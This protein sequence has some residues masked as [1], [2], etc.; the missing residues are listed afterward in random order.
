MDTDI[1]SEAK[2]RAAKLGVRNVLVAT[3]T[4]E[5]V[6]TAQHIMGPN[7][8]FFAVG[9][10]SSSQEKGWVLH[11]GI[12]PE[13]RTRLES[14]G[15]T[16][17]EQDL[18]IFQSSPEKGGDQTSFH[19]ANTAY[20]GRFGGSFDENDAVPN[21]ICR[22]M[23]HILGEF[24]G[25]GLCVCVEIALMAADSGKLPLDEDCVAISTPGGYPL[26]AIVVHPVKSADL[27]STH[28][29]IKD[30]L[31]VPGE[32]DMWFNDGPIP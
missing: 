4:G 21:N 26:T 22:V 13:T 1:F 15:I 7:F 2:D 17:V 25:D 11:C 30:V 23:R 31:F 3:N 32:K 18:S 9:N 12:T 19:S 10:P 6:E 16:V 8:S 29:R 27:F 5:S 24:F 28:F 20:V 14:E